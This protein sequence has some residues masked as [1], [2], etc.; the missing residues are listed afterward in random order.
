MVAREAFV[1]YHKF[2]PIWVQHAS[3]NV[4]KYLH[5]SQ[6]RYLTRYLIKLFG[7]GAGARAGA[8]AGAAIRLC[9]SVEP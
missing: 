8:E 2:N 9:S 5:S 7:A 1:N 3:I 4:K 6:K